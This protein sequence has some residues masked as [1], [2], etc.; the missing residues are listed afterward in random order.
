MTWEQRLK[1]N[2]QGVKL[3]NAK[4]REREHREKDTPNP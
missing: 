2:M 3:P 4:E 1:K